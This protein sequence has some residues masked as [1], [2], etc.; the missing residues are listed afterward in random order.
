MTESERNQIINLFNSGMPLTQIG[1][2]IAVPAK[3]FEREVKEMKLNGE[4]AVKRK[5]SEEKVVEAF[6]EGEH[7]PYVIAERFGIAVNSVKTYIGWHKLHKGK[8]TRHWVHCDRT[9]AIISDLNFGEISQAEIAKKH[10]V[11]RQYI[12]KIKNKLEKG[13]I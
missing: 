1:R 2:M 10:G 12:T 11:S 7:N 8:K 6:L 4:L 3:E 9:N 5:S 13:Q